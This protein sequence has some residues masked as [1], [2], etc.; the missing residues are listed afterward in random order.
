MRS[1]ARR[2]ALPTEILARSALLAK[3]RSRPP[4]PG[5]AH[6]RTAAETDWVQIASLCETLGRLLPT[7]IVQLNRAVA[8]GMA[9]GPQAGLHLI[10]SITDDPA[11]LDY[12]LLPGV[13]G[14]LLAKLDRPAEARLEFERAAALTRNAAEREFLLRRAAEFIGTRQKELTLGQAAEN[15]LRREDLDAE[16]IRSYRQTLQRMCL[17]LGDNMPLSALT[18]AQVNRA[19]GIA[20]GSAAARTWNR[21]RSAIR[22]FCAWADWEDLTSVVERRPETASPPSTLDLD[23]LWTR[24]MPLREHTLWRLLHESAA[25]AKTVLALNIEDLDLDDRRARV[26]RIWVSWRA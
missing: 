16:T 24:D 15:F 9:H 20:W 18:P 3:E 12:H 26:G 13:R 10:D 4:R 1:I 11:L 23:M 22:S 25:G 6:A 21:H 19:F 2:M 14:D 7:P 5:H 8:V 17:T